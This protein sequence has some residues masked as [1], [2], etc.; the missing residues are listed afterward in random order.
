LADVAQ[1]RGRDVHLTPPLTWAAPPARTFS[2]SARTV[3]LR[4]GSSGPGLAPLREV[5]G[6]DLT[7]QVLVLAG[8]SRAPGAIWGEILGLAAAGRGA[9]AALVDGAV[10]DVAELRAAGFPVAA[11]WIATAGPADRVHVV[12]VGG[13]VN[14][15]GVAVADGD[16]VVGD[17]AGIVAV[18]A[19]AAEV[20]VDAACRYAEA[21][22]AVIDALRSGA[23]INDAYRHK[24]EMLAALDGHSVRAG[25]G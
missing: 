16:L 17:A 21:E 18:D 5:L 22:R 15:G 25:R 6:E 2:G 4:V 12:E 13:E 19:A 7:G 23:P 14:I 9:V 8:A 1:R 20:M 24:S 10:R 11:A 3:Q